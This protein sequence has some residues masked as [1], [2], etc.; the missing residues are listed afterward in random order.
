VE[1]VVWRGLDEPRMEIA[2]VELSA[3]NGLRA[4]GTQIGAGYE[5]RYELEPELL[6]AEVVG[7][8]RR[9]ISLAVADFF[10][11]AFSPLLNS[12][13]VL[14]DGLLDEGPPRDYTMA[15]VDVPSLEVATSPQTYEPLGDGLV[16]FRSGDF[17]ALIRF[18]ADGLVE[19]YEGLAERVG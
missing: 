12:L 4:T 1:T 5:L 8:R 14:R 11:L 9:D 15:F 2:Y 19:T 6:R 13:P 17:V 7:G 10:D 16:R 3:E 18:D